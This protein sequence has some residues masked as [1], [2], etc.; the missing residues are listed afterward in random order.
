MIGFLHSA[1]PA[2][3]A[4]LIN[5]FRQGLRETGYVEGQNLTIEYRWAEGQF[6]R[7]P[8]LAADLVGRRVALIAALGGSAPPLAVQ[9]ATANIP[10]LFSSGEVDPV[11]SGLVTSLNRPGGNVTGVSPMTGAL[12]SKRMELLRELVPKAVEIG[13]LA[14]PAN[15]NIETARR[16]AQAA[17][18]DL[19]LQLQNADASTERDIDAAFESFAQRKVGAVYV[20]NDPFFFAQR[21]KMIALAA[22][23]ALPASYYSREFV[24]AGGLTS[25]A[26]SFVDAYRQTG[27]YAGRILKGEK[28][29]EMPIIQS[30]KFELVINRKTANALGVEIPS[31]LLF[32]ADEVIE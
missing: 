10:I 30:V 24:V 8:A 29:A 1:S 11:K 3:Y 6:D 25:Y 22:R 28:P 20:G 27:V 14:N 18:R 31:K 19:G 26:A 7:L 2:P 21:A 12:T 15:P 16:E 9:K 4:H 17:A 32:T 13:Y 5:A 23:H